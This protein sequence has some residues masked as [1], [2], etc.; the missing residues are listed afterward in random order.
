MGAPF[1]HLSALPD[2]LQKP[3]VVFEEW[4]QDKV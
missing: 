3:F 4:A 1:I 2:I